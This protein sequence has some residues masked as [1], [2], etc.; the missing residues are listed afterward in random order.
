MPDQETSALTLSLVAGGFT[1]LGVLAKIAY[2][3]VA[4]RRHRREQRLERFADDRRAAYDGFLTG[5]ERQRSY[6][7]SLRHLL[8]RARSGETEMTEEEREAFPD[9]PIADLV[10][11]LD[12]IRRL[13]RN[14]SIITSAEAIVQLFGDMAGAMRSSLEE[15]GPNDE[16]TWFLLQRFLEDR[17]NEFVHGYREDLG[18]GHPSGAPKRWPIIERN[19]PASLNESE[20]ILR[21][22]I[23]R[24]NGL[25]SSD[26]RRS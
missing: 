16:I 3:S 2:D 1:T 23:P 12:Q 7:Q 19:R 4:A 22:H 18:L 26:Q 10:A 14:Y 9:S 13:A 11:A 24:K 21:T 15:P 17:V 25:R 6:D 20:R 5:V 8:D